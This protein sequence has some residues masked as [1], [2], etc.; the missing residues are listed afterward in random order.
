MFSWFSYYIRPSHLKLLGILS[1]LAG[2]V[3]LLGFASL[4]VF[5]PT[6]GFLDVVESAYGFLAGVVLILMGRYLLRRGRHSPDQDA[7]PMP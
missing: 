7:N 1:L 6:R 2:A 3:T 4:L 5:L